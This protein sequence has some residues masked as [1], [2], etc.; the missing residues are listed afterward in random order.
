MI[1]QP[2]WQ[3]PWNKK[4]LV[5]SKALGSLQSG[6]LE[7]TLSS[8]SSL[9]L[10]TLLPKQQKLQ[11]PLLSICPQRG[12]FIR[13]HETKRRQPSI[14]T[15]FQHHGFFFFLV[16]GDICAVNPGISTQVSQPDIGVSKGK[17]IYILG[18]RT[19]RFSIATSLEYILSELIRI[20]QWEFPSW[21]SG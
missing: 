4:V 19:F 12:P 13:E 20:P 11:S 14:G 10:T 16:N 5:T 15:Y 8:H 18:T 6:P 21:H 7:R 17:K 3:K 2:L 1:A 9:P